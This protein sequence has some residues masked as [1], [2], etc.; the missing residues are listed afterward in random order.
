MTTSDS[1]IQIS[2]SGMTCE[3]CA[4]TVREAIVATNGVAG[5]EVNV[6]TGDVT[7]STNGTVPNDDLE[8]AID[9][10][11]TQAGYSVKS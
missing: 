1:I 7:V 6:A 2:V 4:T 9:E 11:V 10:A 8:F 5:A 3:G